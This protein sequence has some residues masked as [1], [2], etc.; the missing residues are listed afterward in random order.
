MDEQPTPQ[1]GGDG[2]ADDDLYTLDEVA[3]ALR[4]TVFVVRSAIKAGRLKAYKIGREYR[5]TQEGLDA[6]LKAVER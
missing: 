5:V 4:T 6:Y 1:I 2:G 3:G